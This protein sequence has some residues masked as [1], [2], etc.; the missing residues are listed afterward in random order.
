MYSFR[1]SFFIF[2]FGEGGGNL[3]SPLLNKCIGVV[4]RLPPRKINAV[5]GGNKVQLF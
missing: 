4:W 1:A 5:K 3:L 2:L